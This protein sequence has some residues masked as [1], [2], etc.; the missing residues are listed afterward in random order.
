MYMHKSTSLN[1]DHATGLASERI[2]TGESLALERTHNAIDT[3][4]REL[5]DKYCG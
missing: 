3:C 5:K 1:I 4:S 2:S